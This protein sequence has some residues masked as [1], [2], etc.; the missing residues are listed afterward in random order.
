MAHKVSFD[1]KKQL[2]GALD[3]GEKV[4]AIAQLPNEV[5]GYIDE[6]LNHQEFITVTNRA[7]SFFTQLSKDSKGKIKAK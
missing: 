7:G 5:S 2:L 3:R 1:T 6:L 4:R